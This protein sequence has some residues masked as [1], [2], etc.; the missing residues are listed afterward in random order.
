M[1]SDEL[2]DHGAGL[3][4]DSG[5]LLPWL[6]SIETLAE[7]NWCD[8]SIVQACIDRVPNFWDKA[9][10]CIKEKVILR[11]LRELLNSGAFGSSQFLPLDSDS[12]EVENVPS[13][14]VLCRLLRKASSLCNSTKGMDKGKERSRG[15]WRGK[16]LRRYIRRKSSDL[17]RS[18]LDLLK[19]CSVE[20][21][22]KLL[23]SLKESSSSGRLNEA[24][25]QVCDIGAE[26]EIEIQMPKM[27]KPNSAA[28]PANLVTEE[29]STRSRQHLPVL[30]C[31]DS[32]R[33]EQ[34]HRNIGGNGCENVELSRHDSL[35]QISSKEKSGPQ[36]DSNPPLH[37]QSHFDGDQI[38]CVE[39]GNDDD[40]DGYRV[41]PTN[42][43]VNADK[44]ARIYVDLDSMADDWTEKNL[45]VKCNKNG[46]MFNCSDNSCLMAVHE[47]CLGTSPYFDE[48]GFYYCPPCSYKITTTAYRKAKLTMLR[49]REALSAFLSKDSIQDKLKGT[50]S[51]GVPREVNQP[52]VTVDLEKGEASKVSCEGDKG[53]VSC[54]DLIFRRSGYETV[55]DHIESMQLQSHNATVT[56]AAENDGVNCIR[57][58]RDVPQKGF[59]VEKG[60]ASK[61]SYDGDKGDI[62]CTDLV[63]RRS[64]CKTA[65][66]HVEFM[67]LQIH[68]ATVTHA[69]E[70]DGMD[71]SNEER[72]VPHKGFVVEENHHGSK[73]LQPH[74]AIV[75]PT[76][77]ND[78]TNCNNEEMVVPQEGLVV[79]ENHHGS[80]QLQF[81]NAIVTPT[82]ADA[83]TNYINEERDV[84][85]ESF[86]AEEN[87]HSEPD[88]D[89]DSRNLHCHDL[90][91]VQTRNEH[92]SVAVEG[93]QHNEDNGDTVNMLRDNEPP[94][95]IM[96]FHTENTT[97]PGSLVLPTSGNHAKRRK[98]DLEMENHTPRV[99]AIAKEEKKL[100]SDNANK[101]QT[102]NKRYSNPIVSLGRRTRLH[103][104]AE[105]EEILKTA[106]QK[107][108][109]D[110]ERTLPWTKILDFG[111]HIFHKTRQ[112]G[113]LKDKWRNIR[114]KEASKGMER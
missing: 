95:T 89:N 11:Y 107:F 81:H 52:G 75:T 59:V 17:P 49:A 78:D 23:L 110:G 80:K 18:S 105:E 1:P 20:G 87:Q 33:R 93:K 85:H 8:A 62:F 35:P 43:G 47:K 64:G 38:V 98:L 54:A 100:S 48:R 25:N 26:Q 99:P 112:P 32:D 70:S 27:K 30:N 24:N 106:V 91:S 56:H 42:P 6:W 7:E 21:H 84:P 74:N 72:D 114:N 76:A 73:Q 103:W 71:C 97:D 16:D 4:S 69:A 109:N 2:S 102:Q 55:N 44:A 65:N 40:A 58:E 50:V 67:Q 108:A 83:D 51:V 79:E 13:S 39:T 77:D 29:D 9:S 92:G 88:A 86:V 31:M 66:D 60:E 28:D 41:V 61:V 104:T 53:D 3:T 22:S 14:E 94:E 15:H 19:N 82:I 68:N 10:D 101:R 45:C 5:E 63:L 36:Q 12:R 111:R 37:E 96:N 57:E 113:D 90:N 34:S 46:P